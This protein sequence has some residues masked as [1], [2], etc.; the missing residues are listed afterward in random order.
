MS[1]VLRTDS[2]HLLAN[3]RLLAI[4]M[5]ATYTGIAARVCRRAGPQPL[6]LVER[7]GAEHLVTREPLFRGIKPSARSRHATQAEALAKLLAEQ[8]VA[9]AVVGMPYGANESRNVQCTIVERR[10]AQL[11]HAMSTWPVPVLYWDESFSTRRVL[12]S[13]PHLK[14]TKAAKGSHALAACVIL[15]E[16]IQAIAP[17]ER[18]DDAALL[19]SPLSERLPSR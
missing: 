9:A 16:V 13:K 12:G 19:A 1:G 15:E 7:V 4:D 18:V 5:G 6:G 17:L 11:Q 10:V 14:G 3:C 2:I 8:R